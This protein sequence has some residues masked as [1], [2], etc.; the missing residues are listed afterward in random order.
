MKLK[1]LIPPFSFIDVSW[2]CLESESVLRY[3]YPYT[4]TKP[5]QPNSQL[6]MT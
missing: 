1:C 5:I 6:Q 3:H 2:A 4:Y